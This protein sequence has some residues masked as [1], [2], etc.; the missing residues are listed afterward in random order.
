MKNSNDPIG[1]QTC[2]LPAYSAV[3]QPT[4][5]PGVPDDTVIVV[6]IFFIIIGVQPLGR[7]G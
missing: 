7:S 5:P 2:D 1:N 6:M 4:V 3:P